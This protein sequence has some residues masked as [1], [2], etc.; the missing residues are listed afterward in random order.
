MKKITSSIS[1]IF[2]LLSSNIAFGSDFDAIDGTCNV[3]EL[4]DF[5]ISKDWKD[6]HYLA[7]Q[8][9]K[10]YSVYNGEKSLNY[11][12]VSGI[13][14]MLA[15]KNDS[16][17][18]YITPYYL[19]Y[20]KNKVIISYN[21]IESKPYDSI[22]N[23]IT[24][25]DKKHLAFI[26]TIWDKQ[27]VVI[28]WVETPYYESISK[29]K[30]HDEQNSII[31]Y[32]TDQWEKWGIQYWKKFYEYD[33]QY[34]T[35]Y[36]VVTWEN[37]KDILL[38]W[39]KWDKS[40]VF[41]NWIEG[42]EYDRVDDLGLSENGKN[43]AYRYTDWDTIKF[44]YDDIYFIDV[45]NTEDNFM[46]KKI[47][48]D[49]DG[50]FNFIFR[51]NSQYIF[52]DTTWP[53]VY[54]TEQE[55]ISA[56][57][58][59]WINYF[60]LVLDNEIEKINVTYNGITSKNYNN[61]SQLKIKDD[62]TLVFVWEIWDDQFVVTNFEE[63]ER[64]DDISKLEISSDNK[65][66]YIWKIWEQ[67]FL[68]IN[69]IPRE[70][71]SP[72]ILA[73]QEYD[74][75]ISYILETSE[76]YT[77]FKNNIK[78]DTYDSFDIATEN[79][80]RSYS[81][82]RMPIITDNI[83]TLRLYKKDSSSIYGKKSSILHNWQIGTE[84][85]SIHY[86]RT[87]KDSWNIW[88]SAT[89]WDKYVWVY[90]GTEIGEFNTPLDITVLENNEGYIYIADYRVAHNDIIYPYYYSHPSFKKI[91]NKGN[92]IYEGHLNNKYSLIVNWVAWKEYDKIEKVNISDDGKNILYRAQLWEEWFIVYNWLESDSY[93]EIH[94]SQLLLDG[95]MF[96]IAS[97]DDRVNYYGNVNINCNNNIIST[98]ETSTKE[99][100]EIW[101][102]EATAEIIPFSWNAFSSSKKW[103]L[104]K[105][106]LNKSS[107][108]K[109]YISKIDSLVAQVDDVKKLNS[110]LNKVQKAQAKLDK[111]QESIWYILDYLSAK[112]ELKSISLETDTT[113]KKQEAVY[114]GEQIIQNYY[115]LISKGELTQ[116]YNM[117]YSPEMTLTEFKGM[118]TF[119]EWTEFQL[120]DINETSDNIYESR[121]YSFT[122]SQG[123]KM[124]YSKMSIIEWK[125]Q[126]LST[127]PLTY[128]IQE[129]QIK[130][131]ISVY[132][133]WDDAVQRLYRDNNWKKELIL[134][135]QVYKK[136]DWTYSFNPWKI[137]L[138][139][140]IGSD[141]ALMIRTSSGTYSNV[142]VF[143]FK[144]SKLI[145]LWNAQDYW[146]TKDS[147][148]LY[149][150]W[151]A[152]M[153]WWGVTL[154]DYSD[155]SIYKTLADSGDC[156]K[157]WDYN[158]EA[159]S[160]SYRTYGLNQSDGFESFIYDFDTGMILDDVK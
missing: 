130:W 21:G 18:K 99:N 127:K 62:G 46:M 68:V 58:N 157:K 84:Y 152:W 147:A 28:N 98:W 30:F 55:L 123:E 105:K 32:V 124:Y 90:N 20:E 89:K 65:I 41:Y 25:V 132:V 96:Y 34:N 56:L 74:N 47:S 158:A 1:I 67:Y 151:I 139:W 86:I 42:P 144:K 115:E 87:S 33:Y 76:G 53:R 142:W 45:Q 126:T 155:F 12:E 61:I 102:K 3:W 7:E 94:Y 125:I 131:D 70:I 128:F 15:N 108:T 109:K 52:Y 17:Q 26:W 133:E 111:S 120:D 37:T 14:I 150:C 36:D 79:W 117:K 31:K 11:T 81:P 85:D 101:G 71:E 57:N 72:H 10:Y 160:L 140:F 5:R 80:S 2:L 103:I 137:E 29:L 6:I 135:Q 49:D 9:D 113:P 23:I 156:G 60:S 114:D 40:V 78:G 50:V 59:D 106:Y 83:G 153:L 149:A 104:A 69:D 143:D 64:Y 93:Q 159:N 77:F 148:Y 116:A 122:A 110:I 82:Y 54:K 66:F 119:N 27:L 16:S 44:S 136:D 88:Y 95:S 138:L 63:G 43:Y 100:I 39:K 121:I 75:N 92:F 134:D 4:I 38:Q 146:V 141:D 145:N 91:D 97:D 22:D 13:D 112:I 107:K 8:D 118:Y 24:L 129:K 51:Y 154:Y 73:Y 48:L 35:T 19:F